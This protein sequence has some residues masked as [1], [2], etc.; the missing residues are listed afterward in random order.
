MFHPRTR[1]A[2]RG[3]FADGT[4][5][6]VFYRQ[7]LARICLL[8]FVTLSMAPSLIGRIFSCITG[9]RFS[10]DGCENLTILPNISS[11]LS[12][13]YTSH[14]RLPYFFKYAS[15]VVCTSEVLWSTFSQIFRPLFRISTTHFLF[16]VEQVF[17]E[18]QVHSLCY[19]DF[20]DS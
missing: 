6:T 7:T 19:V 8:H 9:F 1:E 15:G 16:L 3:Y 4:Q 13:W 2:R 12:N 20:E 17:T 5:F 11:E 18:I 10:S 14:S